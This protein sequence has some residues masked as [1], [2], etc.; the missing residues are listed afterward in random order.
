MRK[1]FQYLMAACV[2]SLAASAQTLI[3]FTTLA[4]AMDA[5]SQTMVVTSGTNFAA[6][7]VVFVDKEAMPVLSVSGTTIRVARLKIG[8][9]HP[10]GAVAFVASPQSFVSATPSGACTRTSEEVLPR[11]NTATGEI[12]DCLAGQWVTGVRTPLTRYR[13]YAPEPGGT[14]YTGLNTNGTAA[15]ATTLYCSEV[16]LPYS[17]LLTGIA[18]LNGTTVGTDKQY[19]IL[20]DA[21]G[22]LLA[23]SA[24]A[25][26]LTAGASGYQARA[27]TSQY[28]ATGPAQ[29]FACLQSDTG[30]DTVRMAITGINDNILTKG[31]INA[32]FGTI[33][34]LTVPTSFTTAVGPYVYLY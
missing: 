13:V 16:N 30:T 26:V 21:A 12:S 23:N 32:V 15:G 22:K 17:K 9:A 7:Y 19:V 1:A 25:G 20:Y 27:F 34:A 3:P 2:F 28:F 31:Q 6:G 4:A 29:Y 33:P 10:S 5:R 11:I 8:V 14:A 24:V 18:V